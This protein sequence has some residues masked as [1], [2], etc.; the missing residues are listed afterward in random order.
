MSDLTKQTGCEYMKCEHFVRDSGGEKCTYPYPYCKYR[1]DDK[2][3]TPPQRQLAKRYGIS[4]GNVW[5]IRKG[6]TWTSI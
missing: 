5:Y 6:K 4:Q 2:D 1:G 3:A